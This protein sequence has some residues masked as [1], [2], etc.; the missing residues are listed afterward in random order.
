MKRKHYDIV[1]IGAGPAGLIAAIKSFAPSRQILLVEKMPR[2][3]LKLRISGK[4]R[5]NIT[6]A[7]NLQDFL[8]HFGKHGR[9]LRPAFREF[10]NTDLLQYFGKLGVTF[11]L[12]RGG[13][14]FPKSDRASDVV[15]A[16]VNEVGSL[17]IPLWTNCDVTD[18]VTMSDGGF[19]VTIRR[20]SSGSESRIVQAEKV[21][22]A[23][24]GKSYPKTGSDGAGF[25][26]A[27]QL[28]HTITPLSPSLVPLVTKGDTAKNL[29]G[30]SLKNVTAS[31]WNQGKK[32]AEQFGEMLFT[33]FGV[34]GPAI[35]S[36]SH[37]AV[38]CLDQKQ[39]VLLSIDL[40]PALDHTR[41][42]QRL[43]REIHTHSKRH[44]KALLQQLLPKSFLPVFLDRLNISQDKSLSELRTDE[45]KRLRMLLKEFRL[46]VI[47]YRSF[48]EAIVTSGGVSVK[49]ITPKTMESKLVKG[50]YFAGE[51][52]DIDADTG[53]FNLQAAFSTGW[54]AGRSI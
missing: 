11:K 32:I 27:S 47:G 8:S 42:D 54:L 41:L 10:F 50:L 52:I 46:D 34:S 3:A 29:Q 22:L 28:G 49:E 44:I 16:L 25:T 30:L 12:E 14:Y 53:G 39:P 18:L 24:G 23:T 43:L 7:A 45:R 13:R 6:N 19:L 48:D 4:G 33:H 38:Q 15:A 1:I 40:K 9:F 21:V 36:L 2:P 20:T 5:C 26:L 31:L 37:A 17:K 35:L 51:I